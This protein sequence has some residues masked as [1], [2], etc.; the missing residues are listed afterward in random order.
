MRA[1]GW[2]RKKVRFPVIGMQW[3]YVRGPKPYKTINLYTNHYDDSVTGELTN[4]AG[5][6]D[7]AHCKKA[8]LISSL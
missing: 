2:K 6:I 4:R 8:A 3:A 5:S 1:C 7:R